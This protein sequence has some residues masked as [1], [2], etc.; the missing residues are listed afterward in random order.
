M[1]IRSGQSGVG[2]NLRN[3]M[4]STP[5][6]AAAS[7]GRS[8]VVSQLLGEPGVD[9][10]LRDDDGRTASEAAAQHGHVAVAAL[11]VNHLQGQQQQCRRGSEALAPAAAAAAAEPEA[12]AVVAEPTFVADP[13]TVKG[14]A[15]RS[16][17]LR[18]VESSSEGKCPLPIGSSVLGSDIADSERSSHTFSS[19]KTL[20][21]TAAAEA[22]ERAR[23]RAALL[24]EDEAAT[25]LEDQRDA[26]RQVGPFVEELNIFI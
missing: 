11:I 12:V 15:G 9:A 7:N 18:A 6:H 14:A 10:S 23:L 4:G 24:A 19:S 16:T 8:A 25:L 21:G 26:L 5:L 17:S 22:S 3:S 13:I 20:P 2:V 1:Q